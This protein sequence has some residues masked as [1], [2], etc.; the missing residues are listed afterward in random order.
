VLK[1][2][3]IANDVSLAD[4]LH[5][6]YGYCKADVIVAARCNMARTV[7]DFLARRIRLLFLDA[8][9][10]VEVAPLVAELLAKELNY[11]EAQMQYQ[12]ANFNQLANQYIIH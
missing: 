4:L 3:L 1:H 10:A 11:T 6:S 5:P 2:S 8:R 7:E 9:A 12:I